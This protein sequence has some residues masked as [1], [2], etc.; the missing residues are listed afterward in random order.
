MVPSKFDL[1]I[2]RLIA[3]ENIILL[4]FRQ[5]VISTINYDV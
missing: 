4:I 2:S 5:N 1:P 3:N